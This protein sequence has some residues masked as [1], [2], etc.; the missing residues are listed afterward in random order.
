MILI[1]RQNRG[2]FGVKKSL[3]KTPTP[4]TLLNQ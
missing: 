3:K 1:A 2:I 4:A